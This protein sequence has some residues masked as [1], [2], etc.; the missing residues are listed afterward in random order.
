MTFPAS[1][2]QAHHKNGLFRELSPPPCQHTAAI[3][4]KADKIWPICEPLERSVLIT[5]PAQY[6]KVQPTL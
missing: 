5:K 3:E 2:T 4:W 1:A 6:E